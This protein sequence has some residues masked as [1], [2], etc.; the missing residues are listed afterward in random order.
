MLSDCE[1][2]RDLQRLSAWL[3]GLPDTWS[4][5]FAQRSEL[6]RALLRHLLADGHGAALQALQDGFHTAGQATDSAEVLATL[7]DTARLVARTINLLSRQFHL[8][9]ELEQP[10]TEMPAATLSAIQPSFLRRPRMAASAPTSYF[11]APGDNVRSPNSPSIFRPSAFTAF[12]S[13]RPRAF[14]FSR[15]RFLGR[16]IS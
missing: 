5:M 1:A 7:D 16:P 12:R 11:T 6:A 14:N 15:L 2:V 4:V 10:A 8:S 9:F 13:E 3:L